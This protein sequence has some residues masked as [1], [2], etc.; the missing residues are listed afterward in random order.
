MPDEVAKPKRHTLDDH[1]FGDFY[2]HEHDG[3]ADHAAN[4]KLVCKERFA[5][6][7]GKDL[8]HDSERG[9]DHDVHR[10]MR[11]EPEDVLVEERIATGA[12][13]E[14]HHSE[15]PIEGNHQHGEGDELREDESEP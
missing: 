1:M 2:V 4:S 12:R 15:R 6:E 14:E 9:Q 7:V 13:I 11:V 5:G 3:D 10:G 8:E